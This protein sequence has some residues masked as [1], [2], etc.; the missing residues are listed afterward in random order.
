MKHI[1]CNKNKT[2]LDALELIQKNGKRTVFVVDD[3]EKLCGV[4]SDGDIRSLILK[5]RPLSNKISS[6]LKKKFIFAF[7]GDDFSKIIA[8]SGSEIKIIPVVNKNRIITDYI[9]IDKDVHIPIASPELGGNEFKYLANALLST[10]ISST[11]YYID[12]FEQEFAKFCGCRYGVAVSNGTAALHLA[13]TALGIGGGDEVI[14]PDLTFAASINT[15]LHAKAKP[16][17]VDVE[18]DFWTIDPEEIKKAITP[19]TKAIMP[20]HIYG[21]PC[22]MG[23]IMKIARE[24]KLFVVEDCAEAHGARF[25]G[26]KV[27]GFGNI[28]C[29]SFYAN[30]VITTGEG[31]MCVTN[32]RKL[33][34]RMRILR[35]HGMS[36]QRKYWHDEVGFNYRMTNMQAAI[37]CAQLERIERN[38]EA[39][40]DFEKKI[41][42]TLSK[43]NFLKFQKTAPGRDKITWLVSLLVTNGKRGRLL[44]KLLEHK[45]D[46]RPFFYPLGDM[47]IYKNYLFSNKNSRA[48]SASGINLP[49]QIGLAGR[50]LERIMS[51]VKDL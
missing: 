47:P 42:A 6:I 31:G 29:F 38:L 37:G 7:E 12:R 15:V 22:N 36:K 25:K 51:V 39:R 13:L 27:G 40:E 48:I 20:V 44:K 26:K 35:D 21:Q 24:N 1:L 14:V 2:L 11:G 32:S 23:E 49:T 41:R 19:R 5:G 3:K 28:G 18:K 30:K 46:A 50:E 45:I 43:F 33:Y 10:W 8:D 16:V 34:E 17:I 9:Q 4:L